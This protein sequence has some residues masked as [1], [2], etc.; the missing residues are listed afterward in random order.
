MSLAAGIACYHVW[1][2]QKSQRIFFL[3]VCRKTGPD[4]I[5]ISCFLYDKQGNGVFMSD[6]VDTSPTVPLLRVDNLSVCFETEKGSVDVV[7][8]VS[9]QVEKGQTFC[10]VGESGC[11]KSM[12][13]FALLG[14]VPEPGKVKADSISLD[15]RELT[16][17]SEAAMNTVRGRQIGMIFQEPM[18]A[19]NP[20]IRVGDQVA[21]PLI[22][23]LHLSR[24]DALKKAEK[25][26]AMVGIP[27][28]E[29]RLRDFPHQMSGGMRQRVM[30]AMALSCRPR[31]LL[32]DEPTT[33]LDVTIQGQILALLRELSFSQGMG[34]LLIT[35]DLG[36]VAETADKVGVMYAGSIVEQ[37]PVNAIFANPL[38]P[39]TKG[40]MRSAPTP[41][42]S[43]TQRLEA[44]PGTVPPPGA[45]PEGCPFRPRCNRAHDRCL[46]EPPLV[47][48]EEN[49][50]AREVRCW[51]AA[52]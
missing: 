12:T 41:T 43:P 16:G 52:E 25:L 48:L 50:L 6:A 17:L 40:L 45:L 19:L 2:L 38:H 4:V 10:L 15:G 7:R 37:A 26:F 49:G 18:T 21:E 31:L 13:S 20:V 30:I 32:A 11:G 51:L 36:V 42:L 23:H 35:H 46:T 39:Y 29:R 3:L 9:F 8:S 5:F 47:H 44:I 33:A 1:T 28:P 22:Q 24:R 27:A 14:L 34:L